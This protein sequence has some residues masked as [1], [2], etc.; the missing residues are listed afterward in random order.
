[1]VSTSLRLPD[2]IYEALTRYAEEQ[3]L[4]KN[5]VIKLALRSFLGVRADGLAIKGI[6]GQDIAAA[7]KIVEAYVD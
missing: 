6:T 1:M 4:S 2:D 3:E 7:R 5:Q